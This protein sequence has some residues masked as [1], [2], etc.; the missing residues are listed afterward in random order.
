MANI[1]NFFQYDFLFDSHAHINAKHFDLDRDKLIRRALDTNVKQIFDIATDLHTSSLSLDLA[2]TYRGTVFSFI[3]IDPEIFV[4]ESGF[5]VKEEVDNNWFKEKQEIL[6]AL[7]QGNRE[8]VAGIGETG[9]D[10]YWLEEKLKN[11]VITADGARK[12]RH[13]QK[14]LF[15]IHIEL[16]KEFN[17]PLSIHSRGAEDECLKV[18]RDHEVTGIFHSFGGSYEQA[19]EVLEMGFGL[20]I[21]GIS[22]FKNAYAVRG[23]YKKILGK[24]SDDWSYIDFYKRGIFFETDSPFLAPEGKRGQRN[25]P[26]FVRNI[27]ENSVQFLKED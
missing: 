25:E 20:G 26:A 22:T 10:N 14:K 21:N 8:Y 24:I 2:K 23:M 15:E 12:S 27:Y 6:R 4:P 16:A 3:G 13:N 5:E 17:L 18:L 7:I 11:E 19:K 1:Q 9:L